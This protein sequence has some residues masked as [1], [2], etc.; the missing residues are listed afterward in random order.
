MLIFNQLRETITNTLTLVFPN[1]NKPFMLEIDASRAGVEHINARWMT[2]CIP[3]QIHKSK[4][5]L[6]MKS[7]S[8]LLWKQYKNETIL[9]WQPLL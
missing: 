3:K 9:V 5:A 1:F 6:Y 2:H 4:W 8:W 7:K